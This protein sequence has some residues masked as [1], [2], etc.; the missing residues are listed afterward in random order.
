[1][2]EFRSLWRMN[3]WVFGFIL[4]TDLVLTACPS[5]YA[6][7]RSMLVLVWWFVVPVFFNFIVLGLLS[8]VSLRDLV[9]L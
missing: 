3:R 4:N 7:S 6:S 5:R 1:M 9:F 2:G 8:F